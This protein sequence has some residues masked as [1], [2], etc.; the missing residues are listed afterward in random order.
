MW[1]C[2]LEL[3]DDCQRRGLFSAPDEHRGKP[4]CPNCIEA[5][6]PAAGS[7]YDDFPATTS[8]RVTD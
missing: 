6:G 2:S 7:G 8:Y 5:V 4:A 3:V 1:T